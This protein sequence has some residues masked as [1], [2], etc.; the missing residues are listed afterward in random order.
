MSKE[1]TQQYLRECMADEAQLAP[2]LT[3]WRGRRFIVPASGLTRTTALQ[4]DARLGRPLIS[5]GMSRLTPSS[6]TPALPPFWRRDWEPAGDLS[7]EL[8]LTVSHD[9]DD[10][11][12]SAGKGSRR[13]VTER[14]EDHPTKVAAT[15][16]AIVRAAVQLLE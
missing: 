2:L 7:V 3:K 15:W 16:A 6:G 1:W 10:G 4:P 11:T 13:S 14:Y 8:G 9:Q 5:P 12:V